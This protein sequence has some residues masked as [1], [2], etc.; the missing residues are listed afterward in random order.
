V[1]NTSSPG[2]DWPEEGVIVPTEG[3]WFSAE[4]IVELDRDIEKRI[5]KKRN[6]QIFRL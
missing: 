1:K 5:K 4:R 3:G 2:R 6:F